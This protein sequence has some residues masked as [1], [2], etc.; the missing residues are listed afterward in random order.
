MS[1]SKTFNITVLT[2]VLL[3]KVG[4][5]YIDAHLN[6]DGHLPYVNNLFGSGAP[7]IEMQSFLDM[8][9]FNFD[10]SGASVFSGILE[11]GNCEISLSGASIVNINVSGASTI[12]KL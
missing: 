3:L 8:T 12:T 2:L 6:A 9:D 4:S 11:V 7:A 5:I 1:A 10:L